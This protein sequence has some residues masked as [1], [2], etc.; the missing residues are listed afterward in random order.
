[1]R[2]WRVMAAISG[3]LCVGFLSGCQSDRNSAYLV[4]T[5]VPGSPMKGV[6][7]LAFDRAGV[8]HAVSLTGRSLYRVDIETGAVETIIG[9]P[10]G[11]GDDL[12]FGPDGS[13]AWT[14]LDRVLLRTPRG[15]IRTVAEGFDGL[16]S[17]NFGPSGRLFFTVLFRGDALYEADPSGQRPPRL[18]AEKL[19]GLN[20]FEVGNNDKIVGPLFFGN[21]IVSV[22]IES[23]AVETIVDGMQTPAAVNLLANGDIVALGYRNG[24]VF[25][26]DANTGTQ[27]QLANLAPPLDNLAIDDDDRVY[28][29]HSSYNGITELDPATGVTRRVVWGELSAPAGLAVAESN[30]REMVFAA[31]AWSHR[32]IDPL[33][34]VVTMLPAGAGVFGSNGIA[35]D[36]ARIVL[37]N[38]N[39]AGMVQVI[40]RLTGNITKTLFGFGAPYGVLTT[41][42]GFLVADYAADALIAVG[43]G[44][45]PTRTTIATGLGGPVGLARGENDHVYIAGHTDGTVSRVDLPSGTRTVLAS[46]L[47]GPEGLASLPDGT[48]V[49]AEVGKQ[50]VVI[51]D[52]NSGE[53]TAA[54]EDLPIGYDLG[55]AGPMPGL[56]TGLVATVDGTIYV[57]GDA[58][59]SLLRLQ[60]R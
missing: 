2:T 37:T 32:S 5:V 50:R 43:S 56:F 53:V 16:N 4:E 9:P 55:G 24:R 34:G 11:V 59:N 1:M 36:D 47:D 31:D 58:N 20:G 3:L 57:T 10:D 22:D 21:S 19:G 51:V 38:I 30:G 8:L 54:A 40:D 7:G 14:A 25:R 41:A 35:A 13:L 49:V 44:D 29:S 52:P 17:I 28:I 27:T 6:H 42:E 12:A 60:R 15:E 18:I 46:G 33:S 39:P 45:D 48:L 26:I 23:G